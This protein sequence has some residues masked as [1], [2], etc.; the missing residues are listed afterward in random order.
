MTRH[1][2]LRL[3]WWLLAPVAVLVVIG[4]TVLLSIDPAYFKSQLLSLAIALVAFVVFSQINF[5]GLKQLA[6]PIYIFSLALLLVVLVI[7]IESRGAVRWI[8]IF[9]IRLQ[10]SEI[11]K[12]FLAFALCSYLTEQ[13]KSTPRVFMTVLLFL[14][15][16]FV[17]IALQPDLGNA[18][19]YAGVTLFVLIVYGFPWKWFGA[20]FIPIIAV[21]PILWG[22]LHDYQKQRLLT[23]LHPANDPLGASYNVIQAIIAVGSGRFLGKGLSEGTQS[24]LRFLPERQTD[25]IFATLSE[26]L[27]YIGAL[28]VILGFA[29]LCYRVY[30][31][32]RD[33]EDPFG[34]TF[35]AATFGFVLIHFFV[36][37]GMNVGFLPIVGV[38]LP[39]LSF[40]GSSLLSNF[41]FLGIL[42]AISTTYRGREVLEIR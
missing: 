3:D 4:L 28:V 14:V 34:K 18:L 21:S 16:V 32:F 22:R 37:V 15:P 11:F 23:F 8:D 33:V 24:G 12:P 27:G 1:N 2:L 39:F 31:I 17:L 10:F 41:I 20:L 29:F 9:G 13:V 26:G 30:V 40:G 36:N 19:I 42:S 6:L 7:G 5:T 35:A 38:T 25:F